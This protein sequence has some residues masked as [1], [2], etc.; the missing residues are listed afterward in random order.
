MRQDGLEDYQAKGVLGLG[1][2]LGIK[3]GK[4][5]SWQDGRMP[6]WEDLSVLKEKLGLSSDWLITQQGEPK[7]NKGKLPVIGLVSSGV[8]RWERA[9]P[10]AQMIEFPEYNEDMFAAVSTGDA[11]L[12]AGIRSGS[13]LVCDPSQSAKTGEPVYVERVDGLASIRIFLGNGVEGIHEA[14][15]NCVAFQA[16]TG[17][18]ENQPFYVDV[19]EVQLRRIVRIAM[20]SFAI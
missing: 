11:M 15:E 1:E 14:S 4:V 7:E 5:Y 17:G 8:P 2:Y 12:P 9:L 13:V 6:S 16:W 20:V 18:D 10:Y 19:P 3:R